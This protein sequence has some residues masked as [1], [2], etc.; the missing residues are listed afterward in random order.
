MDRRVHCSA[1]YADLN[2]RTA[3]A[4]GGTRQWHG[5]EDV[6]PQSRFDSRI[7]GRPSRRR[8]SRRP[9]ARAR[10]AG[11]DQSRGRVDAPG[12]ATAPAGRRS[13]RRSRVGRQRSVGALRERTERPGHRR[14]HSPRVQSLRRGARVGDARGSGACVRANDP[15]GVASHPTTSAFCKIGPLLARRCRGSSG[16]LRP[17]Q[18]ANCGPRIRRRRTEECPR[19][20]APFPA[21]ADATAEGAG[22]CTTSIGAAPSAFSQVRETV[23]C[24]T[25]KACRHQS[26]G[27]S[28][29]KAHPTPGLSRTKIFPALASTLRRL[30]ESPS[31]RP[32]R[33][34]PRCS[35]R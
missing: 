25:R 14:A 18:S 13:G 6:G 20:R 3:P 2:G 26:R 22:H 35:K 30:M 5:A 9:R 10:G 11:R 7:A 24:R 12:L 28:I 15:S 27:R 23:Q 33:L 8:A 32:V 31:P 19:S 4:S 34:S 29:V 21:R 1:A 17:G 16:G